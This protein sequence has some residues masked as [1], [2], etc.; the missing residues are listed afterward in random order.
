[1]PVF[2]LINGKWVPAV[3]GK[4]FDTI[5][6]S[7]G[8]KL[9]AVAHG[10]KADV[11]IAVKVARQTFD[12]HSSLWRKMTPSERGKMLHRVGDLVTK[13]A[14]ELAQLE[15]IDNGK[16]VGVAK[17]ADVS[18]TADMFYYMYARLLGCSHVIANEKQ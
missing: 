15:S 7:T 17:A 16:P 12:N 9:T 4:V 13:H 11:D 10:D 14:D 2:Q 6:P 5:N 18:L 1:V 8:A 3:S